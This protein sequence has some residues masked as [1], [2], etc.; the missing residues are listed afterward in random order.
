MEE[1]P[2][3]LYYK[4]YLDLKRELEEDYKKGDKLLTEN[5]ICDKFGVSRLTVRR[6]LEEL[7][8]EGLITRKRGQGTFY[9]G[10]KQEEELTRLTGFTDEAAKQGHKT[11]SI[12]LENRLIEIPAEL[13]EEFKVPKD[14]RVVLLKRI[15]FLDEDPYAIETAYLNP[16]ADIRVLNIIEMDMSKES[17]YRILTNE[18]GIK[19][20]HAVE[21][22]EV[23]TL[24][25]EQAKYLSQN[26]GSIAALRTRYTY[27]EDKK[28]I[29]YVKSVYRGDKYKF[30]IVRK[31]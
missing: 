21:T 5:E 18:Y 20:T 24:N 22:L 14:G 2:I 12:V 17:L 13:V 30:K 6:A 10:K 29:E 8:K 19:F 7:S 16:N 28:C 25:K 4:L 3:P 15:R 31:A 26:E 9:T 27:I 23:T 1:A 11:K